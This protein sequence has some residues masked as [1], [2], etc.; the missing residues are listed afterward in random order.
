MFKKDRV[1]TTRGQLLLQ[2]AQLMPQYKELKE[3]VC[4]SRNPK[5]RLLFDKLPTSRAGQKPLKVGHYLL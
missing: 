3:N 2:K 4:H 5:R 1:P